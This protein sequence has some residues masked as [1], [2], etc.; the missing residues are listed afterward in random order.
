MSTPH[1][2]AQKGE[3]AKTVLMP[4]DP[5][6]AK[7]LAEHYLEDV[8]QFNAVRNMFGYTGY[9]HGKQ[10]S[11]MGSGMGQPSIGIY[12]HELFTQYDVEAIIRIGSCGSLQKDVHLRDIIIVQGCCTDSNFAHQ[13][14]LPGT[15]SAISIG[16]YVL[17]LVLNHMSRQ[18]L[19]TVIAVLGVLPIVKQI[20]GFVVVF[21]YHSVTEEQYQ[22]VQKA[23]PERMELMTDLVITSSEKIMHLNFLAVG[24]GRVIGVLGNGKQELSYVREYLSK[25]VAN[26][27]T[28]YKV[29][30]VEKQAMFLQELA[31]IDSIPECTEDQEEELEHVKSYLRSLIV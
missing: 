25:G 22:K 24:N 21:P 6:R 26:W 14:E 27:G 1:N 28:Q 8:H 7:F 23:L 18:N 2:Q 17:G 12:S 19:F 13:Y 16:I 5:L 4:G 11:I 9:Y 10:V 29:Q 3:I 31:R 15:Y 20:V 30:I